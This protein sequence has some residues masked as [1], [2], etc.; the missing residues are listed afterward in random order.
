VRAAFVAPRK[1]AKAVAR[2]RVRRRVRERYR[3]HPRYADELWQRRLGGCDLIFLI[4]PAA[5]TA[6]ASA[7]DEALEQLLRRA[8][9]QQRQ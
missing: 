4:A 3:L 5:M 1:M 9:D 2:N 8:Q 6:T 7:L